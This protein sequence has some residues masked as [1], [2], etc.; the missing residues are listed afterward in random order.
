[1][2]PEPTE[3]W[4][5][6]CRGRVQGVGF[7]PTVARWAGELGLSGAVANDGAG[8]W[9]EAEGDGAA[10]EELRLRLLA[11]LPA[12]ARLEA[13]AV[14]SRPPTGQ[15]GFAILASAGGPAEGARLPADTA[16]CADCRRELE[17][18]GDPRRGHPFITCTACGPRYTLAASL[19]WDRARTA[20]ASFPLC[21]PCRREYEDPRDR[22]FHAEPTSCPACGP[23]LWLAGPDG[24]E[25]AEGKGALERARRLLAGGGILA[26]KGL[27]GFQL[28]CRAD[29]DAAVDRLRERKLRPAKPLALMARE[30][31]LDGL[32][33]LDDAARQA[34]LSPRAPIVIAAPRP[35]ARL[36]GRIAPGLDEIGA[37]RPTTALHLELLRPPAPAVLVA[38]SGNRG[39]EPLCRGNAEALAC[40]ASVADAFLLH[41]RDVLRPLDDSVLRAGPDGPF[42]IRR[43]RGFVPDGEPLPLPLPRCALA[44]GGHL[45]GCG[46]IGRGA[47]TVPGPHAG[48]LDSGG[49]RAFLRESLLGLEEL[50][51]WKAEEIAVDA[52]PDYAS[53]R[54][55][56]ALARERGLPLRAVPHH[57]AH[58]AA[59]LA[60]H[61]LVP[62]DEEPVGAIVLDGTGWGEDGTAWGGEWL[63]VR[64]GFRWG[65][66][67]RLRPLPLV[68]GE[69]AVRE[70][71]RLLAAAL[72]QESLA[73]PAPPGLDADAW[74]FVRRAARSPGWPLA[75]GAGRL[76]E[77]G[78][79]ALAGCPV[80][81]WEGEAAMRLEA[82]A[83][84]DP[85]LA[86]VRGE[87]LGE[88]LL[89]LAEPDA[90]APTLRAGLLELP[91]AWLLVRACEAVARGARPARAA[92][93]LHATF[94]RQAAALAARLWSGRARTVVLGGGCLANGLL[95]AGLVRALADEGLVGRLPRRL[96]PGDGGLAFGQLAALALEAS[97]GPGQPLDEHPQ[98][99]TRRCASPSR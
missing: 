48:D 27:G 64:S 3:R 76:F 63:L 75:S 78:G 66:E 72:A 80:N 52:H 94:C 29:D 19:P 20:M 36:S 97:A 49:A 85:R 11:R 2:P 31:L 4:R 71:W 89:E 24:R 12:L 79:A 50:L 15:R 59:V 82:L 91:A 25:L 38:T 67:G 53:R 58:A 86:G 90:P 46:A 74:A 47:E 28:L 51:G 14:A 26:L 55:G 65:R 35:G 42:V 37:M 23:R 99:E 43:A 34:L 32:L 57:A 61:G 98:A 18:D 40:L 93:V 60:E 7:R 70:P 30:E 69:T 92:A 41:D 68:G 73:A 9:I 22:R 62:T 77:A 5:F 13:C 54:I 96:P 84:R 56:E 45:Q 17:A 95:R 8:A 81:R 6:A 1:M 87:R 88:A 39:G 10:L 83:R 33:E 44:L 16:L 21:D